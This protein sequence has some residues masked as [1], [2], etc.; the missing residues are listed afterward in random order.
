[1]DNRAIVIYFENQYAKIKPILKIQRIENDYKFDLE[2]FTPPEERSKVE[3]ERK[4]YG[5]IKRIREFMLNVQIGGLYFS[6]LNLFFAS[7][8]RIV[9]TLLVWKRQENRARQ[10]QLD[11]SEGIPQKEKKRNPSTHPLAKTGLFRALLKK[12]KGGMEARMLIEDLVETYTRM[13]KKGADFVTVSIL[14]ESALTFLNVRRARFLKGGDHDEKMK[15]LNEFYRNLNGIDYKNFTAI[16]DLQIWLSSL[17]TTI[18]KKLQQVQQNPIPLPLWDLLGLAEENFKSAE[19]L[20][21]R[22]D[23]YLT[24]VLSLCLILEEKEPKTSAEL[25]PMEIF[26]LKALEQGDLLFYSNQW[27]QLG[28]IKNL[29]KEILKEIAFD[30]KM[31]QKLRDWSTEGISAIAF[32]LIVRKTA[33]WASS[34]LQHALKAYSKVKMCKLHPK[35]SLAECLLLLDLQPKHPDDLDFLEEYF[36]GLDS[37]ARNPFLRRAPGHPFRQLI[38]E[39]EKM[40]G[41]ERSIERAQKIKENLD[42]VVDR[43]VRI[44][45]TTFLPKFGVEASLFRENG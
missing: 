28:S 10:L 43:F 36:T 23:S 27:Q 21:K 2:Y 24:N 31:I 32:P 16:N 41:R 11:K 20:R 26:N 45:T 3:N 14:L 8:G 13:E 19:N 44:L 6:N 29:R 33:F 5:E 1:M 7:L 35:R 9:T 40:R 4:T 12:E 38:L 39:A 42:E 34:L 17:F 25:R 30:F 15:A 18:N 37:F 22:V